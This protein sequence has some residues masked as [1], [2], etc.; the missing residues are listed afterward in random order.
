[1]SS[2]EEYL[3]SLLK[4]MG[5]EDAEFSDDGENFSADI[6]AMYA[7]LQQSGELSEMDEDISSEEHTEAS[8][9]ESSQ[10]DD[11]EPEDMSEFLNSFDMSEIEEIPKEDD[12]APTVENTQDMS[13]EEIESMMAAFAN[14]EMSEAGSMEEPSEELPSEELPLEELPLD[15]LPSEELPLD[16]L[17]SEELSSE[18]LPSEEMSLGGLPSEELP[19]EELPL[20]GLP[21][22]EISLGEVPSEELSLDGLPSDEEILKEMLS[23]GLPSE[24]SYSEETPAMDKEE[25]DI[26]ALLDSI[27]DDESVGEINE[28]LSMADNNEAVDESIFKEEDTEA[29]SAEIAALLG[30]GGEGEE[31]QSEDGDEGKKKK[32]VKKEKVKKEKVKKEQDGEEKAPKEPGFFGKIFSKLMEEDEPKPISDENQNIMKEL[33]AEDAAEAGKDKQIKEGLMPG[34]EDG[35]AEESAGKKGKKGKKDKDKGKKKET[36]KKEKPKKEPKPKK[37]KPKKEPAVPEKPGKKISKASMIVV[38]LFAGTVF[39]VIYFSSSFLSGMLQKQRA[40]EAFD[41]RDYAS[42]YEDLYG[43]DLSEE[44][45]MMFHHARTVLKVERRLTRYEKYLNDYQILEALDTLMQALADYDELYAEAQSYGAEA[46][47]NAYYARMYEILE[48]DYGLS[49]EAAH[50]IANCESKV[51]YTRYL[52]ALTEGEQISI[53]GSE[54]GLTLPETE[55]Q[56][57][58]P[59]EEELL[60]PVFAD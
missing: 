39:G 1:M 8:P 50:A 22:E 2:N 18:E 20:N 47:V 30:E 7:E 16:G 58:L 6:D 49:R 36:K 56:D 43:Q 53:N 28:L 19:S 13:Q 11:P 32:K 40:K 57:V 4:S 3:D 48:R 9:A 17:P 51:D 26:L 10:Q 23:G 60:P 15:G 25:E 59:A 35:G 29:A 42:C 38:L 45:E 5:E 37:E 21:S 33:E 44:E 27:Q 34:K 52:T 54:N 14:E 24:E 41:K 31:P 55:M 46:E 12:S